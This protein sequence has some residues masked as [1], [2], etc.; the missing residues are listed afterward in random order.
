MSAEKQNYHHGDVPQALLNAALERIKQDGVEKLSLRA[1]AR[2]IGVSQTAPYR[3]FKDKNALLVKLAIDGFEQ[4]AQCK[5]A[6]EG[7]DVFANLIDIGIAYIEY[8][9]EH[10]QHY[11]LMFGSKIE[12]RNQQLELKEAGQAAFAVIRTQTIKGMELGVFVDLEPQILA[13]CVWSK[14]HGLASLAIDGFFDSKDLPLELEPYLRLQ[15]ALTIRGLLKT[16]LDLDQMDVDFDIELPVNS[17][18]PIE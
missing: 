17:T 4:L 8:A 1:I 16:P 9:V 13:K 15:I 11:Q 2:D 18:L 6:P 5:Q 7:D 14:L 12:Q 10:P 3:H